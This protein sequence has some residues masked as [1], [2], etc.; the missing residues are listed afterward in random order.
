M[1]QEEDREKINELLNTVPND[2]KGRVQEL[3]KQLFPPAAW[4][5][6][7]DRYEPISRNGG[8]GNCA[9]AQIT[10]LT[11]TFTSL[12]R[13]GTCHKPNWIGCLQHQL[14]VRPC[15]RALSSLFDKG[16]LEVAVDRLE[17]YKQ[18]IHL[19]AQ[20]L[21]SQR[22][23]MSEMRCQRRPAACWE[24]PRLCMPSELLWYLKQEQDPAKRG[25]VLLAATGQTDGLS[26]P[27]RSRV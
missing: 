19:I 15:A 23:L 1:E 25:D 22:F 4:A 7:G 16:L 17:A 3:I 11:V 12:F 10:Y 24:F 6:G 18:E 14:I 27:S 2:R 20:C 8:I 26:L 13:K 21:S 5:V 9:S